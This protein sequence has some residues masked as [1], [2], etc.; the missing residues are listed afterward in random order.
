MPIYLRTCGFAQSG[1]S[2]TR[3]IADFEVANSSS[4]AWLNKGKYAGTRTVNE[5]TGTV[6]LAIYDISQ[7]SLNGTKVQLKTLQACRISPGMRNH[8]RH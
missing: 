8:Y 6:E 5:R 4:Y 2:Q 1:T 3:F 7:V